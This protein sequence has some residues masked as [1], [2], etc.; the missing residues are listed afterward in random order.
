MTTTVTVLDRVHVV[1]HPSSREIRSRHSVVLLHGIGGGATS[2]GPLAARL[3]A[4]GL[5]CWCPDA[6]GYGRS[7]GPRPGIGPVEEMA[8][9]IEALAP[10]QPVVLLGTSWGGVIAMDLALHRPDLVAALVIA[11]STRGSGVTAERAAGMLA[12]IPDLVD[13]GAAAVA[14]DRADALTAPDCDPAVTAEVRAT[15]AEVREPGFAAAARYMATTDLGPDLARLARPAL[16]LVGE[17]DTITGVD[18]SRLLA[19]QIPGAQLRI[20]PDA[21]H[22]AIQEQP[23]VVADHVLDFVGMLS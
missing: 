15:M 3:A 16:V 4:A 11:D 13:R 19:D 9:L 21:G 8:E 23:D 1:A 18:E 12:R 17:R 6:P 7:A 20:V 5:D 14:A 2:C 10:G 22:A